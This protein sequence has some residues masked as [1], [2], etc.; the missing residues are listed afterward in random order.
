MLESIKHRV[1]FKCSAVRLWKELYK[2]FPFE[3]KDFLSLSPKKTE[4]LKNVKQ[5][6]NQTGVDNLTAFLI[7]FR[8]SY[9]VSELRAQRSFSGKHFAS[10][11]VL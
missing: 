2:E 11:F 8:L 3:T 5:R 4:R 6:G 10:M 7:F 1:V 9:R